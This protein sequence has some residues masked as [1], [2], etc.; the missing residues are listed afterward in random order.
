M[1][2]E[3]IVFMGTPDFAANILECLIK[4]DYNIVGVVTQ[5]DKKVGRK[6]QLTYSPVK[7][8]ATKY[9]IP[10]FQPAKI[11]DDYQAVLDFEPDLILTAAYGQIIPKALLDYPHYHCI[12]THGSLLPK[13]RGGSPIQ[14][15]LINGETYTGMTL[16]FMEEKMD[17]GDILRQE[18]LLITDED[19]NAT[20]FK[21]LSDLAAKMLLEFLPAYFAG[22][23][24]SRKQNIEEVTYSYNLKKEDEFIHFDRPVRTV[25]NHIRGLLDNPGAFGILNG[26]S[27]KFLKVAYAE[28]N[29]CGPDSV[30]LGLEADYLKI[31]CLDGY[32]KV[33]SIKPEGKNA[34]DA[35]S[36]YNGAG[37]SLV[38]SQ[39][40]KEF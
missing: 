5:C 7:E 24:E 3:R 2:N 39:F 23:Y 12:N 32:I 13:Y 25:F 6:H 4:N 16:M 10:L 35:R 38:G 20:L 31:A 22:S 9:H 36:F 34:M 17:A 8:V 15:A 19:T 28:D 40:A 26:R 14:T 37:R 30:F 18:K 21:K 27:Y 1:A 29:S 11:K 33:Y